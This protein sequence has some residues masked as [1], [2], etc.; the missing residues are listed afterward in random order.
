LS[1][2]ANKLRVSHIS[3]HLLSNYVPHLDLSDVATAPTEQKASVAHT[4]AL[5]A[6]ALNIVVPDADEATCCA[7]VTDGSGDNGIDA[8]YVDVV[9][10]RIIVVQ[11]KWS[12]AGTGTIGVGDLHKTIAGLRD[13]TD[14]RFDQ[15]NS[16]FVPHL[17]AVEAALHDPQVSFTLVIATTG[18]S[19]LAK[20]AAKVINDALA[21]MNEFSE[22]L[23]ERVLG[24]AEL[25]VV[26]K[27]GGKPSKIDITV[28][29]E[30][31][32]GLTEPY[33]AYYGLVD[34]ATL[35]DWYSEHGGQ[36]FDDNLR[37]AL[38]TTPV[39][40]AITETLREKPE[41]FWY[42]NNGVTAL[43]D[44][45]TK[46]A[47]GGAARKSG[48]F[49]VRG[50]S[51]V[52]GAQTV[53][54][55]AARAKEPEGDLDPVRVWI[56]LISLKGCPED[57]S[58][59]VTR[60]TNTQN[61]VEHRDFIALD[62]RQ[63]D[64]QD[65][66]R[67]SLG[68][69]YVFKRGEPI[70]SPGDGFG[71]TEAIV[72]LACAHTDSQFAVLAKSAVGRLEVTTGRYYPQL[73]G[74]STNAFRL[75]QSVR[76]YRLIESALFKSRVSAT[77]KKKAI[78]QQGN[79]VITHLVLKKLHSTYP[80][81]AAISDPDWVKIEASIK[82]WTVDALDAVTDYVEKHYPKNYVTSFFKN[83]A[84]CAETVKAV[85]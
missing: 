29:L 25:H 21:E 70:P 32:G 46:T 11:S 14:E 18:P 3:A 76:A 39:N 12:D 49:V 8:L 27:D 69:A 84:K 53:S 55:L 24:M 57:F 41:H 31:W 1:S 23:S 64:L 45:I 33:T 20:E 6:F 79:R 40:Q 65:D 56:R 82:T 19:T 5:A 26:V 48:E 13:L 43:C 47:K 51:I 80:L 28:E 71:V 74:A 34:G 52:N 10:K 36:L 68:K 81:D 60:N 44:E 54:S 58:T 4:R 17:T 59:E 83:A 75:W 2:A 63:Q 72:A 50:L 78:S 42:F 37:K 22:M 61:T 67:L 66:V 9:G 85:S 30:D 7:H 77:G 35:A 62:P 15:F 73:F 16:K 38:G